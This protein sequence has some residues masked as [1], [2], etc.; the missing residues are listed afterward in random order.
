M[1]HSSLFAI[2][3]AASLLFSSCA[4][5]YYGS[6]YGAGPYPANGAEAVVPLVVGAALVGAILSNNHDHR[7]RYRH[8]GGYCPPPRYGW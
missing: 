3:T 5:P 7:P 1:K 8:H 2:A 4:D 6:G